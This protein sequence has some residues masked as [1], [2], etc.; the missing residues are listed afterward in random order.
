[1]NQRGKD[2]TKAR[3]AGFSAHWQIILVAVGVGVAVRLV[4]VGFAPLYAY[5]N[6]HVDNMAWSDYA[7]QHG[8]LNIYDMPARYAI[9]QRRYN[10]QTGQPVAAPAVAPHAC[11]YP[12]L[13]AL[14]FWFQGATWNALDSDRQTLRLSGPP[15]EVMRRAA[16]KPRAESP[17][18]NTYSSRLADALP[19]ILFDFALAWGVLLLVRALRGKR[20]PLREALAFAITLLAPPLFLDSAFWNQADSWITCLLVWT[21][22]CVLARRF[23]LAGVV[24]GAALLI[25]AQAILFFPVLAFIFIAASMRDRIGLLKS[26]AVALLVAA[27]IAAPFSIADARKS[28][29]PDGALRWFKRSYVET[30]GASAYKRTTLSAFNIWWFDY[31]S[32][33]APTSGRAFRETL[34][35]QTTL[36]GLRKSTLGK[37]L[38]AASILLTF[39]LCAWRFR[40]SRESWVVCAFMITL[41]AFVLPTRVHERYI[42]YCIP[43][44]IALSVHAPRWIG[45]LLLLL[46]VGTAEMIS[47]RF[48]FRPDPTSRGMTGFLALLTVVAF[49][50][51]YV[52]ALRGNAGRL[53]KA[54]QR[55]HE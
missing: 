38:L 31:L 6:D 12:P 33:P 47:Y 36:A 55:N 15:A 7:F 54:T 23:V 48:A 2:T 41:A 14:I 40:W 13:S 1:M 46:V 4:C 50:Y 39:A 24:F 30:I 34:N 8:V 42:Y 20:A 10:P 16:L 25:K 11:N 26:A 9:V 28:N 53:A 18:L 5:P 17:L 37:T 29:N 43:F 27:L 19:A 49:V 35:D 51:S 44:V 32:K 21:L 52:L 22:Y 45:P 3:P